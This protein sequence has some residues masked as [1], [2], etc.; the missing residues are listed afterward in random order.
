LA[1]VLCFF[2]ARSTTQKQFRSIT[3]KNVAHMPTCPANLI[4]LSIVTDARYRVEME[5][6]QMRIKSKDGTIIGLG[7]KINDRPNG[8]LWHMKCQAIPRVNKPN[9][10][11]V[12][13]HAEVVLVKRTGRTWLEWHRI[14][15]HISPQALQ[16]LKRT[17]AVSGMEIIESPEGLNFECE[18][19]IQA[20]AHTRPFPKESS[21]EIKEIG[22]LIVTDVWG[23]AKTTSIGKYRY[24]VSFMDVA[25]RYTH[26]AFL[27]HKD[28][29]I[30]E[31]KAFEVLIETQKGNKI[32]KV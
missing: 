29:T 3:L 9:K 32:K 22:E 18:P 17:N 16:R 31:Y 13:T 24:Y 14:L 30:H 26:V 12:N 2:D 11:C 25:T 20:K 23:P 7:K 27:R 5:R 8:S 28:E 1:E 6:A 4:S 10:Q 15:G 19:C 21:T